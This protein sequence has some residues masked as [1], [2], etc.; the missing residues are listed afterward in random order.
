LQ[1]WLSLVK[2]LTTSHVTA[3]DKCVVWLRNTRTTNGSD[4]VGVYDIALRGKKRASRPNR[5]VAGNLQHSAK[6]VIAGFVVVLQYPPVE[7][8]ARMSSQVEDLEELVRG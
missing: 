7:L 8:K 5:A 2:R 4:S 1:Y 6:V 3:Y